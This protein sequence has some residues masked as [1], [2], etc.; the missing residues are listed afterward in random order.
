MLQEMATS[1]FRHNTI[2][3]AVVKRCTVLCS[4]DDLTDWNVRQMRQD[5]VQ[6][7]L[8][9]LALET[10]KVK[11]CRTDWKLCQTAQD[12]ASMSLSRLDLDTIA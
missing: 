11:R 8:S 6:E 3:I 5:L 10:L 4:R 9:R 1:L 12:M 7:W 2:P